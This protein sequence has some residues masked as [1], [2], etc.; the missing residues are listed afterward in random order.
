MSA[1]SVSP[2]RSA[3]VTRLRDE[4]A[5]RHR[6][7]E[8]KLD[9]RS[10]FA[11][12]GAY[13]AMLERL[14]GFHAPLESELRGLSWASVVDDVEVSPRRARLERDITALGGDPSAT[15]HAAAPM[16][17]PADGPGRVGA[18]YVIEGSALGGA[19]LARLAGRRLQL[20]AAHGAAFFH[21]DAGPATDA[22][23]EAVIAA[24]DTHAE[25]G[26]LDAVI[27][28]AKLTFDALNTWLEA[29]AV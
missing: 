5:S 26:H 8:R 1:Q 21:G 29:T 11:S 24:V 28:G 19:V 4:T 10:S 15:P 7:V 16:R 23:W 18:F 25:A 22:R 3:H 9:V 13:R 27:T 17:L 20:T 12:V 14:L 6:E 2:R